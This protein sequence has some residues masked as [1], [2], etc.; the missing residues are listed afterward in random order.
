M[1][2]QAFLTAKVTYMKIL[3]KTA[4]MILSKFD[5]GAGK[6]GA[7]DGPQAVKK[8]SERLGISF[9]EYEVLDEQALSTP[10]SSH[11]FGKNIETILEASLKLNDKVEATLKDQKFPIIISGDHSNAIGGLSGLKNAMPGKR[12]GVI[13]IDA[14]ADLHSPY[15]TPSGN[16]HGMPLAALS[17]M[18]NEKDK[19]NNVSPEVR[20]NW[21]KLKKLGA[22]GISPKFDLR[23]L[24]I[25]GIRDAEKEEWDLIE[26]MGVRTFEPQD[27]VDHGIYYAINQGLKHLEPCDVLYVSFDADSL[28]PSVSVGTGTT[29]PDG[30]K[31]GEAESI[32]RTLLNHPKTAAFEITEINPNLDIKGKEM[33]KVIA[34]LLHYGLSK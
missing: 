22:L 17:G 8:E 25:I 10:H 27:I 6:K 7:A 26:S 15:T 4:V 29:A 2:N 9:D 11:E 3:D 19:K 32:F 1:I 16:I 28:D 34:H 18:D 21:D 23:D 31:L 33:A 24:V 14:H 20:D 13:W 5:I 12:I 30:L